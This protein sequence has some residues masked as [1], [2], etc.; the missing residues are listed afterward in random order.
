VIVRTTDDL[1]QLARWSVARRAIPRTQVTIAIAGLDDDRRD[2]AERQLNALTRA[3][4]CGAG[5]TAAL[6]ALGL[7]IVYLASIFV[8]TGWLQL[9]LRTVIAVVAV[10]ACAATAKALGLWIARVRFRRA[11]ARLVAELSRTPDPAPLARGSGS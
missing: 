11:C 4:G 8:T 7:A 10:G 6:V 1:E 3:C 2:R 9:A 5:G